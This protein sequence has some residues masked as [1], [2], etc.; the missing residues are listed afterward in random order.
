M[1]SFP[2]SALIV[3]SEASLYIQIPPYDFKI[4][5]I[6]ITLVRSDYYKLF[7][8]VCC[9][10]H[11]AYLKIKCSKLFPSKIYLGSN[12]QER[13]AQFGTTAEIYAY[14]EEQDFGIEIVKVKA[15]GRQRFKVLELR[16][17]SD[18]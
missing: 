14:R 16:T 5:K 13:E 3:L 4:N 15:I 10:C 7:S 11:L 12:V 6:I 17:Q 1:Y 2:K 9:F 18:G 8:H